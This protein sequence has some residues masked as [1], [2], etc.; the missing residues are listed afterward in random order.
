MGISPGAGL[1]L[2]GAGFSKQAPLPVQSSR[3]PG[4]SAFAAIPLRPS[5]SPQILTISIIKTGK[6]RQVQKTMNRLVAVTS[7][8]VLAQ[9]LLA[10]GVTR[11]RPLAVISSSAV[12]ANPKPSP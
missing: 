9:R 3:R 8:G 6:N 10:A 7:K 2:L 11:F 4:C 5:P 1:R 12:L